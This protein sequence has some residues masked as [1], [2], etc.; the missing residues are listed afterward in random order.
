MDGPRGGSVLRGLG[1]AGPLLGSLKP[2]GGQAAAEQAT[3]PRAT[4]QRSAAAY[5]SPV[6][7]AAWVISMMKG[8]M[9]MFT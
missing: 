4:D 8:N 9:P 3:A 7:H 5:S 6:S 1:R 2:G